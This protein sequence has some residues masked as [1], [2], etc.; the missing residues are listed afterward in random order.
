[1]LHGAVVLEIR[2]GRTARCSACC[3]AALGQRLAG[4][5]VRRQ[6]CCAS[7]SA[8]SDWPGQPGVATALQEHP[9]SAAALAVANELAAG[10]AANG[11]PSGFPSTRTAGWRRSPHGE[12]RRAQRFRAAAGRGHGR[13]AGP[14]VGPGASSAGATRWAASR[15]RPS[16]SRVATAGLPVPCPGRPRP[17]ERAHAGAQGE[18]PFGR[19]GPGAVRDHR[20]AARAGFALK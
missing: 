16:T 12:L 3:A 2:R 14:V 10:L 19:D 6:R 8:P 9:V 7:T 4:G 18:R 5:P 1:M 13:S 17:G 20:P 15:T 11:W